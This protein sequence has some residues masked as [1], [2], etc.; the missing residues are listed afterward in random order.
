MG[1]TL[2]EVIEMRK[3]MR[4]GLNAVRRI[5]EEGL[6]KRDPSKLAEAA[7]C[8]KNFEDAFREMARSC[9]PDQGDAPV[10]A[11]TNIVPN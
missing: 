7:D 9:L 4:H 10:L 6:L 8:F 1:Y 3:N 11:N 2:N 5:A